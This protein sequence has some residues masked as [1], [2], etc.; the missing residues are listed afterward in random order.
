MFAGTSLA[1]WNLAQISRWRWEPTAGRQILHV[2]IGTSQH[3]IHDE[4]AT[5]VYNALNACR[6]EIPPNEEPGAE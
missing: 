1:G 3:S 4:E 2:W 6:V 5:A